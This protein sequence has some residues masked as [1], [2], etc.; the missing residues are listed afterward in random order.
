LVPNLPGRLFP[1]RIL[2]DW[3][4]YSYKP[5]TKKK[6]MY[7]CNTIWPKDALDR[8]EKWPLNGSLYFHTILQLELFCQKSGKWDEIP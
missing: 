4:N 8:K 2:D 5:M 6:M 3:P 1:G 7:Y